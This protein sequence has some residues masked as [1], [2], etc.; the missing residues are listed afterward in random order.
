MITK[1]TL[2]ARFMEPSWSPSGADRTQVGPMLAPWTLLSGN[3]FFKKQTNRILLTLSLYIVHFSIC[4]IE[5]WLVAVMAWC[6]QGV[7]V[8]YV[9][10]SIIKCGMKLLWVWISNFIPHITWH[11]I[12]YP[13]YIKLNHVSK[14]APWSSVTQNHWNPDE[15]G[16]KLLT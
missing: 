7:I 13:C 15:F 11:V 16:R 1:T 14:R 6:W 10:P 3:P 4:H 9:I 2:I 8:W 5:S 12:T